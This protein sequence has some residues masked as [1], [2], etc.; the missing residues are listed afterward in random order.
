GTFGKPSSLSPLALGARVG[1]HEIV[2]E[3]LRRGISPNN[4]IRTESDTPFAIASLALSDGRTR[5]RLHVLKAML[6]HGADRSVL[7]D[8]RVME[9]AARTG[10]HELLDFLIAEGAV[11]GGRGGRRD[12]LNSAL[13]TCDASFLTKL[14]R[15]GAV[16]DSE[17]PPLARFRP[18]RAWCAHSTSRVDLLRLLLDAGASPNVVLRSP[19]GETPVFF[20]VDDLSLLKLLVDAG[21]D[22][23]HRNRDGYVPLHFAA[24]G[25]HDDAVSL[26]L[27]RGARPDAVSNAF[28]SPLHLAAASGQRRAPDSPSAQGIEELARTVRALLAAGA[29]P[30]ASNS[31]GLR[32]VDLLPEGAE[33]DGI[34]DLLRAPIGPR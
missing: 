6:A 16:V 10:S 24:R 25:R 31:S 34:R 7:R 18:S 4:R 20:A 12:L 23:S 1:A 13:H 11:A 2:V 17:N 29:D 27:A 8:P 15:A 32:P 22:L 33:F 28:D 5:E 14:I 21:A 3:L 19:G 26:L 30:A 9:R